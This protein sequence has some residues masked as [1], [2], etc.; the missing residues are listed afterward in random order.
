VVAEFG[1][2]VVLNEYC[3]DDRD[4]LLRYQTVRAIFVNGTE[5][6]WGYQAPKEGIREAISKALNS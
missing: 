6:G 5:I 2:S 1:D 4:I 3:A